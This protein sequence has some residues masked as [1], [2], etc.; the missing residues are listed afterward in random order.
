[1]VLDDNSP[2]S[3]TSLDSSSRNSE[4]WDSADL[5]SR[6]AAVFPLRLNRENLQRPG[7]LLLYTGFAGPWNW[8]RTVVHRITSQL[9]TMK[10]IMRRDPTQP[11]LDALVE[12]TSREVNTSRIG[13]PIGLTAG[14]VHAYYTLRKRLNI[15][16]QK[17]LF[18]SLRTAWQQAAVPDRRQAA[19]QAGL[20]FGIWVIFTLGNFGALASYR[21]T[22][23]LS[24][25]PRLGDFRDAIRKYAEARMQRLGNN[26]DKARQRRDETDAARHATASAEEPSGN[27]Y[28]RGTEDR[29]GSM[30]DQ[31]PSRNYDSSYSSSSATSQD[32][33]DDTS[34]TAPEYQESSTSQS[35]SSRS[36]NENA[37]DRIRREN[38]SR[39]SSSPPNWGGQRTSAGAP[40][41]GF[42][43][44]SAEGSEFS[45]YASEERKGQRERDASQRDFDR[46]LDAERQLSKDGGDSGS[47]EKKNGWKRW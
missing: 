32:F 16:A 18:D 19:F 27:T 31:V 29:A 6:N 37:W 44:S 14:S 15:P 13:L 12:H 21:F 5:D 36:S 17:S 8:E 40:A 28:A 45:S 1:M 11:E 42:Q 24:G 25:D 20:R 9:E 22:V 43:P 46:M 23:A 38:A 2:S 35:S 41:Q 39:S 34:P 26:G 7:Q 33:F 47:E 10:S 3:S 4:T 30:S